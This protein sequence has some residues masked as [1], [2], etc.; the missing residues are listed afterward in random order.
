MGEGNRFLSIKMDT[1]DL[2]ET[3]A[4]IEDLYKQYFPGNPFLYAFADKQF[5]QQYQS[6]E[7]FARLF[8]F[9]AGL[10]IAIACMGLFGLAAF[11][12]E[13]RTKEIGI[14]KV[15]GASVSGIIT[16]LSKNYLKLVGIGCLMA[17]PI[18]WYAM[19]RWLQNFAY[20]IDIGIGTFILAGI[21]TFVIALATVSW[22]SI[23]V[24]LTN[25]VDSLRNE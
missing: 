25:P 20:H 8:T 12:T 1:Q 14:R 24:A 6:D 4:R 23:R 16:L 18:G 17:V 9:F 19:H 7:R 5:N 13:Q 3:I 22:Q 11:T 21:L 15:L 10:A 2:S